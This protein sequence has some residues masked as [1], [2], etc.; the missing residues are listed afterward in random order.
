ML[1]LRPPQMTRLTIAFF[2]TIEAS[3]RLPLLLGNFVL[4]YIFLRRF[5]LSSLRKDG[6]SRIY[7]HPIRN[8]A[9]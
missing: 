9:R 2:A 7:I 1:A 5:T 8:V 4:R 6:L 3:L